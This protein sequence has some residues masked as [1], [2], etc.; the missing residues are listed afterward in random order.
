MKKI[1]LFLFILSQFSVFSQM[2]KLYYYIEKDSLLGVKNQDGKIIIPAAYT[3]VPSIYDG[4]LK[5]EIKEKII[6][7]W[8]MKEG[9]K[10]FDR[11]GN[12]LF[13]PYMFDAGFDDFNEEYMRFTENKKVGFAN[14]NGEKII[15]AQFDWVSTMNFGFAIFCKGCYFDRSK[16]PEHP[17]LVGGTWGYI[18]KNGVEIIPTEKRNHP[19]DFET[20]KHQFVPYQ[21]QYNAKEIQ[22]LDFFEKRKADII[23]IY[24]MDCTTKDLYFEIVQKP[25]ESDPFYKVKTFEVCDQYFHASDEKYDDYKIF[26]VSENGKDFYVTYIDLVDHKERSEYV[27]V[28]IPVDKWIKRSLYFKVDH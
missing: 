25:T 11:K 28:K 8:V 10:A 22:I 16:D 14:Q 27:E 18:N 2:D 24:K 13:E 19:K 9:P 7:F 3:L 17:N 20:E 5:E 4:I 15:L 21:F 12:F 23:K 26:K 1:L 6:P